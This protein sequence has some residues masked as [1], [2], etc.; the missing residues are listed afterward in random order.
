[1]F[2]FTNCFNFL[3][4]IILDTDNDVLLISIIQEIS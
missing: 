4:S 2:K 3:Q 1:M